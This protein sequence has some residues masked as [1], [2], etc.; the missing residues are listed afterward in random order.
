VQALEPGP[1]ELPAD[2]D[3]LEAAWS[4]GAVAD[5]I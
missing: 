2:A 4:P 5:D 3:E 1:D